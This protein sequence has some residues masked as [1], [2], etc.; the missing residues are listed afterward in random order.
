M[1]WRFGY[2]DSLKIGGIATSNGR[3]IGAGCAMI[4]SPNQLTL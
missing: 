2:D 3:E 1:E 4:G